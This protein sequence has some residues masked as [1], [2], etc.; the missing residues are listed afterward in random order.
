[1]SAPIKSEFGE[2]GCCLGCLANTEDIFEE[3]QIPSDVRKTFWDLLNKD[4]SNAF[5]MIFLTI[6]YIFGPSVHRT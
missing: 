2:E 3:Q 4:V 1:M 6:P 5:N